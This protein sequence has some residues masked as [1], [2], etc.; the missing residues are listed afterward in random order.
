MHAASGMH[1]VVAHAALDTKL[2]RAGVTLTPP[3]VHVPTAPA[4]P[5]TQVDATVLPSQ[6][7][8]QHVAKSQGCK[9]VPDPFPDPGPIGIPGSRIHCP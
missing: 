3:A 5:M 6:T 7:V 8:L 9:V 4:V 2:Q 1:A